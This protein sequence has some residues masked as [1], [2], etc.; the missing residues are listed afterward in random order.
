MLI[1]IPS[2]FEK[3]NQDGDFLWMIKSN[4][5]KNYLFIFN[6]NIESK[7]LYNKGGGNAI[8]RPYTSNNPNIIVPSAIGIPTGSYENGGFSLLNEKTKQYIDES[9]LEIRKLIL[10]YKYSGVIYSSDKN[11]II[12]CGI[13]DV[14]KD[15]RNYITNKIYTLSE[16][17]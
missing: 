1:I 15:V 5:Y 4:K 10:K 17:C 16:L 8:I 9:I 7:F 6:D 12:G 11:G 13:F 3:L 2:I 14:N